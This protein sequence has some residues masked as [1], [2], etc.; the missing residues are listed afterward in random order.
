MKDDLKFHDDSGWNEASVPRAEFD[1][2]TA[3]ART[4]F[5]AGQRHALRRI[6]KLAIRLATYF[7]LALGLGAF[8][9]MVFA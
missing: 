1:F 3:I 4:A 6:A 5:K 7:V 9:L 8:A 2:E